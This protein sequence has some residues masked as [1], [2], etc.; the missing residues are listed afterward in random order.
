[1]ILTE[2]LHGQGLGNQLAVYITTRVVALDRGL[3][4]GLKG[5]ENLG[6]RRYNDRGL[7]F[8]DLYLGEQVDESKVFNQYTEKEVRIKLNHSEHDSILGCD[9]RIADPDLPKVPDDTQLHGTMQSEDYFYHRKSD[10]KQWLKLKPEHD[11]KDFTSDDICVLNV[12]DYE[13]DHTLFLTRNYWVKAIYHMLRINP[14]MQFLV[15]TENPNMAKRLLPE[16]ADNVYHFD[17]GKD[18]AIIKNARWLILSNSSFAYFP[19]FTN[20]EAK[21][22]IAPKY[23]ARHNVSDGYWATGANLCRD[24]VYMDREGNLQT[25]Q[26]CKREFELYKLEHQEYYKIYNK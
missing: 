26:E 17:V 5:I 11:C 8:M 3:D 25:Y 23:W 10:I 13:G 2:L 4:F 19:A 22:I 21:L 24:F 6:D 12:R 15:I 1:M 7:Y 20:E 18:Y 14:N 9:I 16:L